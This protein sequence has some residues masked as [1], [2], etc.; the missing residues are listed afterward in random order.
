[1]GILDGKVAIVT[2]AGHGVGRG[3]AVELAS[4]G[5][6]VV[7][8]DLG[9]AV[10]GGGGDKKVADEVVEVIKG[11]GGEAV[12]N[13]DDVSDFS[14]AQNIVNT[15]IETWGKLDVVV[16][17]A[18]ILRDKMIFSMA[19]EDFDSVIKVHLKGT[20]NT[21]RHA[22]AYWRNESK[23]GRQPRASVVN[24]VSSAGLQGQASQS[25]YGAAKAGIAALTIIGSL[26]LGRYGVRVN[27]IG[28]GGFTR[29]VGQAYKDIEIKEPEEYTEFNNMNP[30]NSA[31]GVAWLASD[32]SIPVTGQVL[33]VVGNNLALYKPWELGEQFLAKDKE[34]NPERWD[35]VDIGQTLNKYVFN[36]VNPGI[37]RIQR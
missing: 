2:G 18:G 11:R 30:G 37:A 4:H 32:D 24:T 13:Y 34:G 17:N 3:E 28:P 9:G 14:G 10:S 26:E 21:M 6:R 22:S 7:V 25:N 19:E 15:A 8:N 23:E 1:M 27:A 33:R 20:W 31:P 16:N 12:A 35:P 36:T 29:M 5:A